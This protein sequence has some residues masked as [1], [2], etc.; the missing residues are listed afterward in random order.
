[1]ST[2]TLQPIT[3]KFEYTE[4]FDI[5]DYIE[6][7]EDQSITPSQ[8]HYKKWAIEQMESSLRDDIDTN[9]FKL[10]LGKSVEVEYEI[11]EIEE[12]PFHCGEYVFELTEKEIEEF[13]VLIEKD[14]MVLHPYYCKDNII[15][16][17]SCDDQTVYYGVTHLDGIMN[18]IRKSNNPYFLY[19][20]LKST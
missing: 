19:T 2:T 18:N 6:W 4:K 5:E 12:E 8:K 1:M 11:E 14:K 9:Q 3:I 7:C 15:V 13:E 20:Y 16:M 17:N 10:N